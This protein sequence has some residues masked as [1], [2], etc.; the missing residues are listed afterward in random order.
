MTNSAFDD[1]TK[2]TA[3]DDAE[4]TTHAPMAIF[5][6]KRVT[7]QVLYTQVQAG[8]VTTFE[9]ADYQEMHRDRDF[10]LMYVLAGQITNHLE[11]QTTTLIAGEGCLLNPQIIHSEQLAPHTTV[12]FINLSRTLLTQLLTGVPLDGPIFSFLNHNLAENNAWQRN[13]LEFSRS[14]PY[15]NQTFKIILDSLQQEVATRKIGAAYF[16]AGLVLR[17]LNALEDTARFSLTTVSLDLS[18]DDYLVNRTIRL[19]ENH[20]G[21]I[22]RKDIEAALHYNAE[23]LNRLL[24]KQTG[25]TISAYAQHVRIHNAQQLLITTDL[26]VQSIAERLGFSNEVYFYHYFKKHVQL[27]PNTYR[28]QFKLT[29]LPK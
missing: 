26:T 8:N 16:Q 21:N 13:Y 27:S 23:Y 4:I 18:K 19:I 29:N 28:Q 2:R 20:Y 3:T 15:T 11:D 17:L 6:K 10:E 7:A 22:A 1:L 9:A 12:M 24:K 5:Y 14:I 25:K